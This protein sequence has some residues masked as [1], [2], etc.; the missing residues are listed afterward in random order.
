MKY[1]LMIKAFEF[2]S[3][4]HKGQKRDGGEPYIEH[5]VRVAQMVDELGGDSEMIMAAYLHDT[6][7]DCGITREQLAELFGRYVSEL[8]EILTNEP[9]LKGE[10]Q[11]QASHRKYRDAY[12]ISRGGECVW[13][14]KLCDRLDNL[15]SINTK[16]WKPKRIS[17]YLEGTQDLVVLIDETINSTGYRFVPRKHTEVIRELMHSIDAEMLRIENDLK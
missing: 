11:G 6:M 7:E 9:I 4:A 3:E 14:L 13:L 16:V 10:T 15:R 8:V 5:P 1:D 17:R 2:A 12:R